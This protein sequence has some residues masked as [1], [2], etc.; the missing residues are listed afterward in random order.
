MKSLTILVFVF[1]VMPG[2]G[3]LVWDG[4]PLSTR[5]EFAALVLFVVVFFSQRV[6]ETLGEMLRGV[7]W[8]GTVKPLVVV[9]CA[10]KFFSFA[11]SPMSAGFGACYRS[12]YAPLEDTTVCEKSYESPF[13][14]G[15]GSQ[16]ARVSRVDRVVDFGVQPYDWSLPFM[17]EFPRLGALWM[18]RF[19]FS[20]SYSARVSS[21]AGRFVPVRAIGELAVSVDDREAARVVDYDRHFVAAVPLAAGESELLVSFA[22]SDAVGDVPVS[23]PAPRGP[24]AQLLIGKPMTADELRSVSRVLITSD[25]AATGVTVSDRD[26]RPIKAAQSPPPEEGSLLRRYALD[27]SIPATAL[28]RGPLQVTGKL[29]GRDALL[30]TITANPDTPLRPDATPSGDTTLSAILTAERDAL[31]PMTPDARSDPNPALTALLALLDLATLVLLAALAVALARSMRSDLPR[32]LALAAAAW[33]L[34]EPLDAILPGFVGGGRELVIPYA[35]VALAIVALHRPITRYPLAYL[36][37]TASVLATQ[38][39]L[40]HITNNHPGH[41]PRWW[42]KLIYYWRDSDWFVARGNGRTIY[43]TESLQANSTV[44]YSQA[45][46]RYL[47]FVLDSLL[48]ENDALIGLVSVAVGFLV[49]G[50]LAARVAQLHADAAGRLLAAAVAFIGLVFVG[51]ELIVAFGFVISSEYPTWIAMLAVTAFL[52]NP[53][54]EHRVWVTTT[55]AATL[56]ALIHFRPNSVFTFT[57][58]LPF[59]AMRLQRGDSRRL[60]LQVS[61]AIAAFAVVLPLSLLHNVFYGESFVPFTNNASLNYQFSWTAIWSEEGILGA[62]ATIWSQFRVMMYWRVPND[63]NFAIFFWGAQL[64]LVAA[65]VLRIRKRALAAP[66]TAVALLPLTHVL[67]MLKF[68]TT[69]YYPRMIAASSVLCLCAALIVW[70]RE[71][72]TPALTT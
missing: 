26:G 9:L 11:W 48:G 63:P 44:F 30:A 62:L 67:P 59:I 49:V 37:P 4:L 53:R 45:A 10:A 40:D 47:A 70:P 28:E 21:E 43:L 27:V 35:I 42:G 61:S 20:A 72:R 32:A 52:I 60:T 51:D 14:A 5:A 1:L 64:A 33:I 46:S 57:A 19:S 7:R 68:Q 31:T 15:H 29:N 22:Y 6:R 25:T 12:L 50:V 41:D 18:T 39:V 65:I 54:P 3:R 17:N 34:V 13:L 38:K 8:S 66:I 55:L 69:S 23:P 24:Y 71:Q 56:A 58:L 16:F 2:S 36:L